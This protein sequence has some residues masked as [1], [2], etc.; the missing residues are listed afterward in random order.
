MNNFIS[1]PDNA[2]T[3]TSPGS[4]APL[5]GV[6]GLNGFIS[7]PGKGQP[8]TGCGSEI[9]ISCGE[10]GKVHEVTST[11]MKRQCPSCWRSWAHKLALKSSLRMWSGGLF[12]MK[13]RRGFRILHTVL[14]FPEEQLEILRP[15]VRR[16]LKDRGIIGG[17]SIFHPFRQDDEHNFVPDGY[18]HFHVIGIA[19]GH[20]DT[21]QKGEDYVFKVIRDAKRGN[22][23][24]FQKPK[25]ISA[26][27]Y[28]L[29]THCGVMEGRHSLT[30]FGAL[31]YNCFTMETWEKMFPELWEYMKPKGREC[32]FCGSRDT[33]AIFGWE[34]EE[35]LF[36]TPCR[37]VWAPVGVNPLELY[38]T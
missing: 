24:G 20:V 13:G 36:E 27:L 29:L 18:V 25:E 28:Y 1:H 8:G 14:S 23:K 2:D 38:G 21:Q 17:L 3:V 19:P 33:H 35:A 32:P 11:C 16:I 10:C 22:F 12:K 26:C 15:R 6:P 4:E 34:Y 7:L 30:W 31:S 5:E 37:T 9:L